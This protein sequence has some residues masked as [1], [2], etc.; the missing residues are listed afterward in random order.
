MTEMELMLVQ[1]TLSILVTS[2]WAYPFPY[3]DAEGTLHHLGGGYGVTGGGAIGAHAGGAYLGGAIHPGGGGPAPIV[4]KHIYVHVPPPDPDFQGPRQPVIPPPP[5]KKHYKIVFIKAPSY[6]Q[7]QAPVIPAPQSDIEKTLI[8]VLHRNPTDAAPI[9]IPT[10]KPTQPAKPEVYFIR[11][12]TKKELGGPGG[13]HGGGSPH[14]YA[15]DDYT[16]VF[17]HAGAPPTGQSQPSATAT[18]HTHSHAHS[19]SSRAHSFCLVSSCRQH[20]SARK[21]CA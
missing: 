5:P 7:V 9:V 2:S 21:E 1:G 4:Q 8:Y 14:H 6:P 3:P 15:D 19:F 20:T 13:G 12:K 10:A 17:D 16:A 18:S 11:Y